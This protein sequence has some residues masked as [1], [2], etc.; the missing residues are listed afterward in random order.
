MVQ[1]VKESSIVVGNISFNY[2]NDIETPNNL[3]YFTADN[4][5]KFLN[6]LSNTLQSESNVSYIPYVVE[7]ARGRIYTNVVTYSD[8]I[9]YVSKNNGR[10]YLAKLSYKSSLNPVA[11]ELPSEFL[12]ENGGILIPNIS[13][14]CIYDDDGTLFMNCKTL[15]KQTKYYTIKISKDL[16]ISSQ[17]EI[18]KASG[19]ILVYNN[20]RKIHYVANKNSNNRLDIVAMYN[21]RVICF[22]S[23][24][25]DYTLYISE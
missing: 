4:K 1:P 24:K 19:T 7:T 3:V 20:N 23:N 5:L 15:F 16:S 10:L 9:Y 17:D 11:Y 6:V 14:F 21:D 13:N 18:Q 12:V 2:S 25:T 8:S 22:E